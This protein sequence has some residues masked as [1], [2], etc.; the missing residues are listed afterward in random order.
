M[1]VNRLS[2]ENTNDPNY[3]N[4]RRAEGGEVLLRDDKKK[5]SRR[6]KTRQGNGAGK[7][8]EHFCIIVTCAVLLPAHVV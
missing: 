5:Q 1:K 6:G 3:E 8:R 7:L 4:A 2:A